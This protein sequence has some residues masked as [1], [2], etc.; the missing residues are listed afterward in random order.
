[1]AKI[2]QLLSSSRAGLG[3]VVVTDS[4]SDSANYFISNVGVANATPL[5]Q[6]SAA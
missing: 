3:S 5:G 1:M 4:A 2:T 6:V